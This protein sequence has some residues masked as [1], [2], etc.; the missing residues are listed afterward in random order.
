LHDALSSTNSNALD[1]AL[2]NLQQNQSQAEQCRNI[3]TVQTEVK[4]LD[5]AF[6]S[7]RPSALQEA[8]E[9][10]Q[11]KQEP[12]TGFAQGLRQL[13]SLLK[14]LE[15]HR[16]I[17]RDA[18]AKQ[19]RQALANL[20]SGMRNELGNDSRGQQVLEE[21]QKLL[22]R[23]QGLDAV[24][25]RQLSDQLERFSFEISKADKGAPELANFEQWRLPPTYRGRTEKYFQKL[26]EQ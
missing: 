24:R 8:R 12:R 23:E 13:D 20:Q 21:L 19:G 10:D 2:S 15:Q 1:Q 18:Q 4:T 7:A 17:S 26:S 3:E 9:H 6:T 16:Q 14:Q 11:L 25:L 22:L 5:G